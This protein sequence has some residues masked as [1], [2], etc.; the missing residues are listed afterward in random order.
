MEI[1]S[2]FFILVHAVI[3]EF[4][5]LRFKAFYALCALWCKAFNPPRALFI[6]RFL[7]HI[8]TW[9]NYI[10][11]TIFVEFAFKTPKKPLSPQKKGLLLL[12]YFRSGSSFL[13][14]FFNQNPE[15]FYLFEPLFPYGND[16]ANDTF[17]QEKVQLLR[18]L[19]KCD[20]PNKRD[21]FS[22]LPPINPKNVNQD[23]M[24]QCL[25]NG[26]CFRTKMGLLC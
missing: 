20:M 23:N 17:R 24:K 8:Q 1:L 5:A 3:I 7:S 13:G 22:R 21:I 14:E 18:S 12:T 19:L 16:C 6:R 2:E 15:T 10:S 11:S 4:I 26:A 9:S 25:Y